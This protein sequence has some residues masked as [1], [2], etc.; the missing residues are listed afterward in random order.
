MLTVL[1]NVMIGLTAATVLAS[2]AQSAKAFLPA[3]RRLNAEVKMHQRAT[4]VRL[5]YRDVGEP[6]AQPACALNLAS[7]S[8]TVAI[9]PDFSEAQAPTFSTPA[10]NAPLAHPRDMPAAA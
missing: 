7:Q 4:T 2:L 8:C 10:F 3:F 1:V 9:R 6:L 5:S